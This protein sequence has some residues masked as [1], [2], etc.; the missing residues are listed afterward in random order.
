MVSDK[1]KTTTP[2]AGNGG[3]VPPT[4]RPGRTI[5]LEAEDVTV[6]DVP[7]NE[8]PP[9]AARKAQAASD[10]KSDAPADGGTGSGAKA[11][12]PSSTKGAKLFEV[13]KFATH[14][15]AGLVGGLVGVIGA[16]IVFEPEPVTVEKMTPYDDAHL[17][18]RLNT[19]DTKITALPKD[20]EPLGGRL[21]TVEEKL[22]ALQKADPASDVRKAAGKLELRVSALEKQ[23]PKE[24]PGTKDMVA[25]L[26]KLESTLKTL[27]EAGEQEGASGVAQSAALTGRIDEVS[28]RLETRMS[29]LVNDMVALKKSLEAR[30]TG[31]VSES[32]KT[33]SDLSARM[34]SFEEKIITLASRIN[35]SA[36]ASESSP[37]P[38]DGGAAVALAFE[39]LRRAAA[40]G[41]P[42]ADQLTTLEDIAPDGLDLSQ[43]EA[44]APT[45]IATEAELLSSLPRV[46]KAARAAIVTTADGSFL[47]RV[48]SN[49]RS[50]VRI[51]RI[52]PVEGESPSQVLS[53]MEAQLKTLN[54]EGVL[55]EAE[56]LKGAV[57]EAA[58]PW[59]DK[60]KARIASEERLDMLGKHL[61]GTLQT[62]TEEK[63]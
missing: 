62:T 37:A 19:M 39:R 11:P 41:Y 35:E 55:R 53:R 45:G 36:G 59:M 13:K 50:A 56:G 24:L 26:V 58:R 32:G 10:S 7:A 54:L 3:S 38:S 49:A 30:V 8:K 2:S 20:N 52:G 1:K 61:L 42:Y 16:G 25:R 34:E 51:R 60:A 6:E 9:G 4:K 27:S 47:E 5:D 57:L 44:N 29:E 15:A 33:S 17:V 31:Q 63:R 21:N 12:P 22:A 23:P 28:T 14:L 48:V 43:F 18:K 40:R 46:L